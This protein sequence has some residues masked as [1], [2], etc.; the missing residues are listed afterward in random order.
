MT[1]VPALRLSLIGRKCRGAFVSA[2]L[3]GQ[4]RKENRLKRILFFCVRTPQVTFV[5]TEKHVLTH[6]VSYSSKICVSTFSKTNV[7]DSGPWSSLSVFLAALPPLQVCVVGLPYILLLGRSWL[8]FIVLMSSLYLFYQIY[9]SLYWGCLC[10]IPV[11]MGTM[12]DEGLAFCGT[13]PRS[14]SRTLSFAGWLPRELV[15]SRIP[16]ARHSVA[17]PCL[18]YSWSPPALQLH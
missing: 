7:S 2:T 13:V 18:T 4:S 11:F 15:S 14:L 10:R 9:C 16:D 6:Y 8:L 12:T 17:W 3:I 5:F 1:S